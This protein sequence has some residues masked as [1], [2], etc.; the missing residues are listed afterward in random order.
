M[1]KA[2]K[3]LEENKRYRLKLLDKASEDLELQALLCRRSAEDYEFFCDSFAWTYDP[4]EQNPHKPFI[5]WPKQIQNARWLDDLYNRSQLGEKVNGFEDKPRGIGATVNV[6][7]W[8]FHKYCFH[9]FSARIGSRKEAFVDNKGDPDTLFAKFDYLLK[10]IPMWLIGEHERSDMMLRPKGGGT[11][12]SIVGESANPNFGRGGRK[13]VII[14]DEFG[15]WDY[16]K[17]S[18][19]SAGEATNFRLGLSTPPESGRDSHQHK[20]LTGQA[21]RV[22]IFNFDWKDDPRRDDK[23]LEEAKETKSEE[24]FAREVLKSYEGTTQGKVYA[25]TMRR[26]RLSEVDY[27]PE[28]PLFVSWDFGLDMVAMIWWQKNFNTG[29][30]FMIDCYCNSNKEIDFYVP[31]VTGEIPEYN[32]NKVESVQHEYKPF[33]LEIIERHKSWARTVTHFGD[34]DARKRNLINKDSVKAHLYKESEIYIESKPWGGREWNDFKQKTLLLLRRLEINEKRCEPVLSAMRNAKYPEIR[35][36]SQRQNEPLKPV[37]DWTS[38]YRTSFEYFADNEPESN[39]TKTV[40][41]SV[42]VEKRNTPKTID[43]VDKEIEDKLHQQTQPVRTVVSGVFR[44]SSKPN[45]VI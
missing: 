1:F 17:S 21:G 7:T 2:P 45:R 41:E 29:Q 38:H 22:E 24:E 6:M 28:L 43:E 13:N 15:F 3:D 44:G 42:E 39:V 40:V 33:E 30:V 9:D 20:L 23:W 25:V 27:H 5:L 12:N 35:E 31:F 34:P 18:W 36:G 14:F 11:T 8:A 16:A 4:R 37:H 32:P 26:A 19:E 10:R